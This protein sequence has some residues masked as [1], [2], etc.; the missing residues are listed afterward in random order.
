MKFRLLTLLFL[1]AGL[2]LQAQNDLDLTNAILNYRSGL[3]DKAKV[4][5]DKAILKEK[6]YTKPKGHYNRGLIYERCLLS[7]IPYMKAAVGDSGALITYRSY[8]KAIELD[9]PDGEFTKGAKKEM[10]NAFL[11]LL[12][13]GGTLYNE[14]NFPKAYTHY[15]LAAEA[16]PKDT[17]ALRNALLTAKE[18]S[19][20]GPEVV[21]SLDRIRASGFAVASDYQIAL[22]YLEND[23]ESKDK[24]DAALASILEQGRTAFPNDKFFINR[25]LMSAQK[26]GNTGELKKKLSKA[27]M[28]DATNPMYPLVLGNL[29]MTEA[30]NNSKVKKTSRLLQDSALTYFVISVKRDSNA[31][32]PNYNAGA[33]Y[34][35]RAKDVTDSANSLPLNA[36]KVKKD[37]LDAKANT[38]LNQALPYFERAHRIDKKD[39]STLDV[40]ERVYARLKRDADMNKITKEREA[41]NKK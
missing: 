19:G 33:I 12:D 39:E 38:Y 13:Q 26:S 25:E 41:L 16:K 32:D 34:Y 20:N 18:I 2:S 10:D 17:T 5:I 28:A 4:D 22:Y 36:P 1:G 37:K 14:K 6:V 3:Y 29:Y 11:L 30:T 31:F 23:P 8:K 24:N 7:T 21:K 9:A 27:M 35:N 40:L 15:V